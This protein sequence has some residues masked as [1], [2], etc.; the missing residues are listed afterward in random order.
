[1]VLEA[2][3]IPGGSVSSPGRAAERAVEIAASLAAGRALRE[4]GS[5]VVEP[6]MR[7]ELAVSE[8]FLGA[9]AA[10]VSGRG[11][12]IE[13]MDPAPDGRSLVCG[14]APLRRLFGFAGELRSVTE[15]RAEYSARFLR[16][17]P[18]PPGFSD[19]S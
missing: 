8:D 1:V 16:F 6:V 12:R 5:R 3:S 2:V 14:A 4:A 17:E 18:V 19:Y 13:S 10:A 7:L 15:G 11:G 9:A